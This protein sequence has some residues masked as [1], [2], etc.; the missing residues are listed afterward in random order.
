MKRHMGNHIKIVSGKN[1]YALYDLKLGNVYHLNSAAY[2]VIQQYLS[3]KNIFNSD[4][5]PIIDT[6]NKIEFSNDLLDN[7]LTNMSPR[8]SYV[9]LELTEA[10][11]LNCIHCYGEWGHPI[12]ENDKYLSCSE[13]EK[14]IDDI[15]NMGCKKIQFIGGEPLA[16][17]YFEK[18]IIY[19]FQKGMKQID[20]FTNGTLINDHLID[21][22]NEVGA[23]IRVSMYGHNANIH[24]R[25][26]NRQGSFAKTLCNVKKMQSAGIPVKIAVILMH[27]NESYASDIESFIS[28]LGSHGY[29]TIRQTTSGVQLKHAI[30]NKQILSERYQCYPDFSVK[31]KEFD[32]NQK[33]NNCWF[34]K[35][36]I[37]SKGDIMPCIFARECI[38]GN[39]RINTKE[40][41]KSNILKMWGISKDQVEEC[42]LC[43]YR[44]AC[45]DCRPLAKGLT[46]NLLAKYPRCCYDPVS[47]QWNDI[48]KVSME[49]G[50]SY[51]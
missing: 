6:L 22:F 47:G 44:Y 16:S 27:E 25:I 11:N 36:A 2:D 26:T 48:S 8:L 18:L 24:D 45:H 10:C 50:A 14:I 9:W 19:A 51:E 35:I 46:G 7:S 12:K 4:E 29:D 37:T 38:L 15:Y 39:I 31:K 20:V 43:E 32:Y 34:G 5:Q 42:K 33:W 3:G 23:N 1:G 40:K 17:P 21:V 41:I 30:E 13:W 28:S 49:L